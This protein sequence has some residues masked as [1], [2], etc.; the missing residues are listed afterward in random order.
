MTWTNRVVWQEGMFLRAQH[1]QQQDRWL[2][3]LVRGGTA[4]MRPYPWGVTEMAIDRD[5][6]ATGRFALTSASGVFEDGTPF[7]IPGETDHPPP[8][9]LPDSA[10]NLVVYLAAPVRQSG[11]VE[12]GDGN[13]SAGRYVL[14]DFEAYDTHSGSPQ[15]APLLVGRLR[16]RY[17]L[18]GEERAGYHCIGLARI[19][20]VAPDRRVRLDENWIPPALICAA[21]V[22]LSGMITEFAAR[23]WRRA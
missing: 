23:L 20:E 7:S 1:F 13:G 2:E 5:L 6:L 10:R 21:A 8:L 12:V 4:A 17:L 19:V 3:M 15:P 14:R 18:E 22:P 9:D 16:L 11:A